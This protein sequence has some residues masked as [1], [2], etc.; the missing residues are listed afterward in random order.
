MDEHGDAHDEEWRDESRQVFLPDADAYLHEDPEEDDMEEDVDTVRAG[1]AHEILPCGSGAEG[2]DVGG[3]EIDEETDYIS[4]S[5]GERQVVTGVGG[6]GLD[7][8]LADVVYA[9]VYC[10]GK[11]SVED[12]AYE[13]S[14]SLVACCEVVRFQGLM[15]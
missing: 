8:E 13:L 5:I 10:G 15:G 6:V 2:K 4:R 7:V 3:V 9:V 14:L 12:E 1:E 11:D